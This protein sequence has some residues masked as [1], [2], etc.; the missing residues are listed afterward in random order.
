[1]YL[2][3]VTIACVRGHMIACSKAKYITVTVD[4]GDLNMPWQ[5]KLSYSVVVELHATMTCWPIET[6]YSVM[7]K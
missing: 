7:E 2:A 1:M 5:P 6:C 3:R 4:T